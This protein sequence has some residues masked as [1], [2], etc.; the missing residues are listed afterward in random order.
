MSSFIE[1]S[2]NVVKRSCTAYRCDAVVRETTA[3]KRE[4]SGFGYSYARACVPKL[5]SVH[6]TS[7]FFFFLSS[8]FWNQC[9]HWRKLKKQ[10]THSLG[11]GTGAGMGALP[12]NP[13]CRI[14]DT[15]REYL[16]SIF[17]S[18]NVRKSRQSL[19]YPRIR[20]Q[21]VGGPLRVFRRLVWMQPSQVSWKLIYIIVW[22]YHIVHLLN[23]KTSEPHPKSGT[24][25][26]VGCQQ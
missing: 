3:E 9:S 18:F 26:M 24:V 22:L 19:A 21:L 1:K 2:T 10:M 13:E 17:G 23:H 20:E 14:I 6:M 8:L 16:K 7:T 12:A 11:G 25:L 5:D 4:M 15:W